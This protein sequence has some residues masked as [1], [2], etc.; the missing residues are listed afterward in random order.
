MR[1][2]AATDA[3]G[4]C[5]T[6]PAEHG[7]ELIPVECAEVVLTALL[8]PGEVGVW[9]GDAENLC[10]RKDHVDEPLPQVIVAEALNIPGHALL[11]VG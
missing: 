11:G 3:L 5:L 9:Q 6:A 4:I 1:L 8:I 7:V 10:L 2:A